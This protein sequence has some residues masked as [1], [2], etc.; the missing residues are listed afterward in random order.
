M[1]FFNALVLSREGVHQPAQ[2]DSHQQE[3]REGPSCILQPIERPAAAEG[4]ECQRN[5]QRK[6]QQRLK[7]R[8]LQRDHAGQAF[9]PRAVS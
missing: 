3:H 6:E 5:N 1:L 8:K 2:R 7:M 9:R 4:A